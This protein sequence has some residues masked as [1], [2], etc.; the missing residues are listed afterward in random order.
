MRSRWPA[1]LATAVLVIGWIVAGLM[2]LVLVLLLSQPFFLP[3]CA[4]YERAGQ[5][6]ARVGAVITF[7]LLV[8]VWIAATIVLRTV[9]GS[10]A[11]LRLLL[12]VAVPV[13]V[14]FAFTLGEGVLTLLIDR[15][16]PNA[17]HA[18]CW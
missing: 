3:A 8:G 7:L 14:V 1:G 16:A 17:D 10:R 15:A 12:G 9:A 6:A 18:M 4:S 2:T 5:N 13:A 11:L